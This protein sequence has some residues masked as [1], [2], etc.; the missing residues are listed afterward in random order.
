[1]DEIRIDVSLP[2]ETPRTYVFSDFPVTIGR[3]P[4]CTLSVCHEAMPRELCSV[5]NE[6]GI[7]RLEERPDLTNP[8]LRNGK[9][10]RGG[11]TG[12]R[13]CLTVGPVRLDLSVGVSP[14]DAADLRPA[15]WKRPAAGA[16]V[17]AGAVL[18][19][20]LR[21][22]H[23]RNTD[24]R[25]GPRAHVPALSCTEAPVSP[26]VEAARLA[27]E[28]AVELLARRPSRMAVRREAAILLCG[29]A[30]ALEAEDELRAGTVRNLAEQLVEAL[31]DE[32]RRRRLV[33]LRG[34][35]ARASP[36]IVA[37]RAADLLECMDEEERTR[38]RDLRRLVQKGNGQ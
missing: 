38:H 3:S 33:L 13:L 24:A 16:L 14:A 1:V 4:S 12:R 27:E 26:S 5:W 25:P 11:A 17:I 36:D 19:L 20:F 18:L 37:H 30:A 23:S 15:P 21:A 29:A 34:L 2:E 31:S 28:R 35:D 22:A 10:V 9:P 7:L 8:L 32:C 6:G